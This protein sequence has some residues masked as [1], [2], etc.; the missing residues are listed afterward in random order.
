MGTL[1]ASIR[2][3]AL[4]SAL[5]GYFLTVATQGRTQEVLTFDLQTFRE[6]QERG[7]PIVLD[8]YAHWC[9]AC[10]QRQWTVSK[11]AGE[12]P[13]TEV[14]F[15][16]VDF[17]REVEL[18]RELVVRSH[19]TMLA[20]RG[21]REVGRS[22]GEHDEGRIRSL[23]DSAI[24]GAP[25]RPYSADALE[26]ALKSGEPVVLDFRASWCGV[27]ALRASVL[28]ELADEGSLEG[29]TVFVADFDTERSLK[30]KFGITR[31]AT[32]VLLRDGREVRRSTG[33]TDK[34]AIK[35]FIRGE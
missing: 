26:A 16:R 19:S 32:F 30:R 17:D 23:A 33:L 22:T 25:M 13:Y 1:P 10:A 31:Q 18:K 3:A 4:G 2:T 15:F 34:D 27:C 6:A 11:V 24:K 12:E 8:F 9:G 21:T 20:L 35:T 14:L 5:A 29:L 7:S 28:S